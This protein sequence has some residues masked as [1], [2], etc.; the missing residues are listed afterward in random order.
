MRTRRV[1]EREDGVAMTQTQT[2]WR[3]WYSPKNED[4]TWDI[5]TSRQLQV[6]TWHAVAV[7][8]TAGEPLEE[9]HG[10]VMDPAYVGVS[11]ALR[12]ASHVVLPGS[13]IDTR[14]LYFVTYVEDEND[15]DSAYQ[16]V[17]EAIGG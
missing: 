16:Q 2:E 4:G 17:L 8:G 3:A 14:D 1:A 5:T 7:S 6:I 11:G 9:I 13:V 10:L 12:P 15:D